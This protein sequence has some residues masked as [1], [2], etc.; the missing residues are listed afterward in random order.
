M[1]C[2]PAT[3]HSIRRNTQY[4]NRTGSST[5][6]LS[7]SVVTSRYA[8]PPAA[9]K[10]ATATPT[11]P[12][13]AVCSTSCADAEAGLAE[14]RASAAPDAAAAGADCHGRVPA[15]TTCAGHRRVVLRHGA[16]RRA[17]V[18]REDSDCRAA[19]IGGAERRWHCHAGTRAPLPPQQAAEGV[20]H[21]A[22]AAAGGPGGGSMHRAA[23]CAHVSVAAL[24]P[25]LARSASHACGHPC[26]HPS[27][28]VYV[29]RV[30]KEKPPP[31]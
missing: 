14:S 6:R 16:G 20:S 4:H 10:P 30:F 8:R 27:A 15:A 5:H 28:V 23:W 22:Y 26:S 17:S 24:L 3:A 25:A 2:T 18:T 19:G 29:V 12:P 1:L 31:R 13:A 7:G 9:A 21:E 11:S